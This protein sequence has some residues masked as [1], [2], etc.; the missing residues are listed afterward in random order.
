MNFVKTSRA[1]SKIR[2]YLAESERTTAIE[3]GKKLFEKEADRYRL[4]LKKMLSNGDLDRLA[5]DYGVA[6]AD[7]LL[8]SIGYGKML[9]RNLIAKLLPP[10]RV[11][12]LERE[13]RPTLKQVVKRALGLEDRIVVKGV[14]DLVVYR[15]RCCNPIRGEEIVGYITRGKG[16]SV[17][18]A[19]CPNVVNLLYDPE[20]RIEVE[21]DKSPAR[22]GAAPYTVKLML[23]VED[24]KGVLAAVSAKIADINTNIKD[25]EARTD[26]D[27]HRARIEM[28]VEISDVKHLEKVIKSLRGVNGVLDVERAAR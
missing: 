13:K 8:A 23:E 17:H 27:D 26:S 9:P 21:W 18:S 28:T 25:M 16:V 11:A 14:D 19:T 2:H 15:A 6:R 10:D 12:E 5:P 22:D 1:R 20:R 7:D 4:S 3:L 24:R